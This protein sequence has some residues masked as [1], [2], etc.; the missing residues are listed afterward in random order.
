MSTVHPFPRPELLLFDWALVFCGLGMS[1]GTLFELIRLSVDK[2]HEH[3]VYTLTNF[4]LILS[5]VIHVRGLICHACL[6]N[7]FYW[8]CYPFQP[9]DLSCVCPFQHSVLD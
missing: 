4:W 8:V 2:Q 3:R 5:G 1:V 7:L 6:E 9:T